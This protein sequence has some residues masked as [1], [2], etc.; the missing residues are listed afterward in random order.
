[1]VAVTHEPESIVLA[2]KTY[3]FDYR[4]TSFAPDFSD[5]SENCLFVLC[6]D[7]RQHKMPIYTLLFT[8]SR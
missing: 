4:A 7:Q 1:M 5:R 8:K 2:G 6:M 3:W